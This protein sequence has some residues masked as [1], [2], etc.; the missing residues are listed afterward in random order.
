M[1]DSVENTGG[2]A[3]IEIGVMLSGETCARQI[4]RRCRAS[5]RNGKLRPIALSELRIGRENLLAER[6][7]VC[8]GVDDLACLCGAFREKL[9]IAF[10]DAL[11]QRAQLVP[12]A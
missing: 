12:G 11:Q 3:H 7:A 10:A 4:F 9:D 2:A 5:H 1:T 8:C 6:L